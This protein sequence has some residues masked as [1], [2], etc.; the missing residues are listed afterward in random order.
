MLTVVALL[1]VFWWQQTRI[2]ALKYSVQEADQALTSRVD[3]LAADKLRF[4]R[5]ELVAAVSLLDDLSRSEVGGLP[6]D[7]SYLATWILDVYMKK[8]IEGRSDAEARQAIADEWNRRS[9]H[10]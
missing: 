4:H 9:N 1:F 8:R 3:T 7:G 10:K 5:E 6:P 2:S